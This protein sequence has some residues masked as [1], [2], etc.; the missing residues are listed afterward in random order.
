VKAFLLAAGRGLRFRPVTERIP[1][2][3]LPFLNVPLARAHLER[4]KDAGVTEAGVNLHHL[5]HQIEQHLT[6][7]AT[8]L[9][10]L[11]FFEEPKILGTAGALRNAAAFL[12][13]GDFFVVNSDA[14]IEP[15]FAR[16]LQ[17]HRAS[18]RAATLCV[19]ENREPGRYTPLQAEGDRITAFGLDTPRPLL[20]T[21]VCVLAPRLL[22]RIPPG[23]KQLAADLWMPLL[24]RG[25][26][27]VG[28]VRHEG[29]FSDLGRPSDFLRA[30]LEALERR[31]PFPRG[32]GTFDSRSGVLS[33]EPVDGF[34]ARQSVLGRAQIGESARIERSVVF[35]GAA[36]RPRALLN[37]CLLAG[38]RVEADACFE[39]VLLWPDENGTAMPHPLSQEGPLRNLHF[40]QPRSPL[41]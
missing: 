3:L 12:E 36:I 29:P 8:D 20:Y 24:S 9:P 27:E 22:A 31:G 28:F 34:E 2:P 16:L 11:V 37:G 6:E 25:R 13:D 33:L 19:V 7:G 30:S 14:S 4:L 23:E 1:K 35:S 21:G 41:R 18:G 5:G 40:R 10:K 38:G 39:N 26:E 17:S 15:D 32:S